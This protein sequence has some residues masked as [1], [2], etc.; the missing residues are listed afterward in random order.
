MGRA[1][2]A[3]ARKGAPK[4]LLENADINAAAATADQAEGT[5]G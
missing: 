4:R 3:V 2:L 5:S 1:M